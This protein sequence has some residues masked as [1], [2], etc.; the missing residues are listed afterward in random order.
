MLRKPNKETPV[1]VLLHTVEDVSQSLSLSRSTLYNLMERGDL[2]YVKIGRARRIPLR[3]IERLIRASL[4]SRRNADG[5]PNSS[6]R[7]LE[8]PSNMP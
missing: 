3:E 6:A 4:I 5:P 7:P 1:P 2:D 8:I